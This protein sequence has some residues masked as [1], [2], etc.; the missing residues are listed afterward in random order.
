[1]LR[2]RSYGQISVENRRFHYPKFYV[3]GVAPTNHS[4]HKT[5]L[6]GLSCDIKIWTDLSFILSQ[7][8]RSTDGRTD[9]RTNGRTEFS[10]LDRVCIPCSAVKTQRKHFKPRRQMPLRFFSHS[11]FVIGW[12]SS[13]RAHWLYA[14]R[15]VRYR[16]LPWPLGEST[17]CIDL[18]EWES[19]AHVPSWPV[20]SMNNVADE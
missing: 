12:A 3:E 18:S 11:P 16:L 19:F 2:L 4:S 8:M 7:S 14:F 17:Y 15:P 13:S 6:N 1:M 9:G 10:S 5:R 20:Q